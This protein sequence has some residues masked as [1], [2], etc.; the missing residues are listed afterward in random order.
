MPEIS[1][2]VSDN[3]AVRSAIGQGRNSYAPIQLSRY[4]TTI[5]NSGTCYNLTLVDKVT[6]YQGNVLMDNQATV[7]N[8][9]DIDTSIW[10]SVHTGMR[11]VIAYETS[12]SALINRVNVSVAGKTGTAQESEDKPN[13]ALFIS[14][15]PY[16]SPE[17]SVTCVIQ[18][19]YSS[20]N[21]KEVAGFIYAYIYDPEELID[22]E[23]TGDAAVS[24]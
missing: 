8:T 12:Q 3:D 10:N 15:A 4:V 23:M 18:N 22:E 20:G 17:I 9:I 21:A 19:G 6:D 14:Y 24:D 1:P 7:R 5:A 11:N 16:E 13:H 2:T